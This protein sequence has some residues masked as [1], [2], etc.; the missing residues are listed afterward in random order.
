MDTTVVTTNSTLGIVDS[1]N[2]KKNHTTNITTKAT[3]SRVTPGLKRAREQPS[4]GRT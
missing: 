3:V 2:A 4:S 1:D